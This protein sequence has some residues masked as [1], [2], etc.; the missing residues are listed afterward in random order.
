MRSLLP[1]L[2]R[3]G[4]RKRSEDCTFVSVAFCLEKNDLRTG[5]DINLFTPWTANVAGFE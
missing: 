2:R 1:I 5:F 4:L 3:S